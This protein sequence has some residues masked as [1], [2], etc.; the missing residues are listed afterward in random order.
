MTLGHSRHGDEEAVWD[1]KLDTFL[2]AT[3]K[4]PIL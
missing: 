1:Q 2:R 3:A 4:T